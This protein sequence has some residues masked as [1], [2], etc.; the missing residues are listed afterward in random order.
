MKAPKIVQN[1]WSKAY[2]NTPNCGWPFNESHYMSWALSWN[3]IEGTGCNI[4]ANEIDK[5]CKSRS[6]ITEHIS[7][8]SLCLL[9]IVLEILGDALVKM[10]ALMAPH[11]VGLAGIDEEIGLRAG[12]DTFGQEREA[13]LGHHGGVVVAGDDLQL[14]LQ[15]FGLG[16]EEV[17]S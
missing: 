5:N 4:I 15:V 13:M 16:E 8:S 2:Q 10:Y 7:N 12:L 11:V 1:Y 3:H 14:A 9:Q 17:F 6:T